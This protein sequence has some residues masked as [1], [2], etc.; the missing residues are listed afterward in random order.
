MGAPHFSIGQSSALICNPPLPC[1]MES[2]TRSRLVWPWAEGFVP[3]ASSAF[4]P[5]VRQM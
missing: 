2:A 1:K 3:S 5:S 4:T